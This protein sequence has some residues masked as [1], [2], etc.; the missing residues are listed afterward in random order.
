LF[1]GLVE[2]LGRIEATTPTSTGRRLRIAAPFAAALTP[3][4][5]VAVSG[6]CLTVVN[7]DATAFEVDAVPVTLEKTALGGLRPGDRVNLERAL[8]VGDRLG[9][10]FVLGHVD[11]TGTIREARDGGDGARTFRIAFD[12]IHAPLLILAG[13]VAVD[14]IS[15]TVARLGAADFTVA[16]IP[17]TLAVTTAGAWAEGQR[18]NLE[19]DMLGKYA[20]RQLP[21][22]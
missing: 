12:P 14:G 19:F 5:S 10:H 17:H 22:T 21:Q 20:Q 6:A 1:T 7:F 18:V 3:G 15:L 2:A 4:E 13:S 16:L 8:R 9:G 11:D